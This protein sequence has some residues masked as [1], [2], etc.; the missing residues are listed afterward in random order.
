MISKKIVSEFEKQGYRLTGNHSAI[1]ICNWTKKSL[2]NEGSCFKEKFYGIKSHR[3]CQMTC[4]LFNCQ[5]LC[6]HCWRDLRYSSATKIKKADPAEDIIKKSIIEQRKI[7]QGFG[8]NPRVDKKKFREALNP[9]QFAISLTGEATLYPKLPDLINILKKDNKTVFL[10]T[11]GLNPL[12]LKTLGKKHGLPTQLYLSMNSPDKKNYER[13]H[14]S[15]EKNAW[16]KFNET[17]SLF[18]LLKEKTRTT[19]R[20]T[21]VRD[22]N[23]KEEMIKDYA[24]LINKA[25]P[26]FV[27]I[28]GYMSVGS[29]RSRLGYEKMPTYN[30]VED[31]AKKLAGILGFIVLGKHEF[32]RVVLIGPK[33]SK[34]IMKIR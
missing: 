1:K 11:N 10:V 25:E 13:W 16:K 2:R 6:L 9:N 29:A 33:T 31:Y 17:L 22:I 3:C 20:M 12:M 34:K 23:M 7:L 14:N 26:Y 28:K 5:N 24:S 32:S 30:E 8:G 18:K 21:L 15:K 27:E 19:I 4:S